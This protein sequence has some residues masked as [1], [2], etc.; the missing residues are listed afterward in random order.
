MFLSL[1][2]L[3]SYCLIDG[4]LQAVQ[5]VV[6]DLVVRLS[7]VEVAYLVEELIDGILV[8]DLDTRSFLLRLS[9]NS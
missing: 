7:D 4:L 9:L 3:L 5:D 1:L 2:S 8:F 6:D